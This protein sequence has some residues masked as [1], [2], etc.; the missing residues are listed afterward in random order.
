MFEKVPVVRTIGFCPALKPMH[1]P[2]KFWKYHR[3]DATL[4]IVPTRLEPLGAPTLED[5]PPS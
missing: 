3:P 5:M 4:L 1:L 2:L